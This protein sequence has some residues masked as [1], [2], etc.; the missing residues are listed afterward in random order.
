MLHPPTAGKVLALNLGSA[1]QLPH[2]IYD[3]RQVEV[4]SAKSD[5]ELRG[6]VGAVDIAQIPL[7]GEPIFHA[8]P[9][10]DSHVRVCVVGVLRRADP[11]V[12]PF[13][14]M[15]E[16]VSEASVPKRRIIGDREAFSQTGS[17]APRR[18][19]VSYGPEGSFETLPR[20]TRRPWTL[21]PR[22]V[23]SSDLLPP[24][25]EALVVLL[26]AS[27]CLAYHNLGRFGLMRPAATT[28]PSLASA[29]CSGAVSDVAAF[30][31]AGRFCSRKSLVEARA[32]LGGQLRPRERVAVTACLARSGCRDR[33]T[34]GS[35]A[36]VRGSKMRRF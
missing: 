10:S 18:P 9:G 22:E 21:H 7:V 11:S 29:A 16:M 12:Q 34:T 4:L 33:R 23:Q 28:S 19:T 35:R 24:L 36:R 3:G 27:S 6:M 30:L 17:P 8:L 15:L 1:H 25:H 31:S 26:A 14:E 5:C 13:I 2:G 20:A 32:V